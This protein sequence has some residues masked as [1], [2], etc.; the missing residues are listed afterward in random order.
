MY[1]RYLLPGLAKIM[2][3]AAAAAGANSAP[4]EIKEAR[5]DNGS[6]EVS[7][8]QRLVT[9]F[10]TMGKPTLSRK[11][12]TMLAQ[13]WSEAKLTKALEK[14]YAP[15]KVQEPAPAAAASPALAA[16]V[17]SPTVL[18]LVP[19]RE[20]ATQ[21]CNECKLF[22]SAQGHIILVTLLV[23]G[24]DR[25]EQQASLEKGPQIVVATPGRLTEVLEVG[26]M[27]SLAL[28]EVL[29]LDEADKMLA[30]GFEV[31]LEAVSKA[32]N[33]ARQALLFSATFPEKA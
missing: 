23:G 22:R 3:R 4:P 1:M 31:Q 14:R 2:S 21:V 30:M 16:A 8:E 33:P 6:E 10:T 28:V 18:V 7:F 25:N 20:L 11:V 26:G 12:P 17:A 5:H 32:V 19:T 29:V 24:H 15:N 13:G 9:F 27:L